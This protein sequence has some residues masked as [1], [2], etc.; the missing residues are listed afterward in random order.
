MGVDDKFEASMDKVKGSAKETY[1]KAA[2]DDEK[3]AEG[4]A[5]QVK[6]NMKAAGE[7]VKDAAKDAFDK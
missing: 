2:N 3:I 4:K 1:G 5:D 6:G 7:N